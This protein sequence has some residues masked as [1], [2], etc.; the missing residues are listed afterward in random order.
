M[1][2]ALL[3]NVILMVLL[4][5]PLLTVTIKMLALMMTAVKP[6]EL[7]HMYKSIAMITMHV[8]LTAVVLLLVANTKL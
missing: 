4:H 7:V 6:L 1:I 5:I 3:I 8:P 2:S